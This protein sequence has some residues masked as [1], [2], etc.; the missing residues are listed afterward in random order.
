MV[1]WGKVGADFQKLLKDKGVDDFMIWAG[2]SCTTAKSA[3]DSTVLGWDG[4]PSQK[5]KKT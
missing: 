5:T 2:M 1:A 3:P 4:L